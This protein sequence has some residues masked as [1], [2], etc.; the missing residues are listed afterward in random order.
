MNIHPE[1]LKTL[2][3]RAGLT[4]SELAEMLPGKVSLSTIKR[5]E[6]SKEINNA[7]PRIARA[8][9]HGLNCRDEELAKPPEPPSSD[10]KRNPI[11]ADVPIK[12]QISRD[13]VQSFRMNEFLYG[14]S[15][16]AQIEMAPLLFKLMAEGSLK[17]RKE[18][19]Q[20]ILDAQALLQNEARGHLSYAQRA[21]FELQGPGSQE[22][23]S[24]RNKDIFG[25][26]VSEESY[27]E[28]YDRWENNPFL[29]YIKQEV[30]RIGAEQ[31][32]FDEHGPSYTGLPDFT[33]DKNEFERLICPDEENHQ[34]ISEA[35]IQ[36]IVRLS[37]LPEELRSNSKHDE[38]I[39]WFL[40]RL[41]PQKKEKL[42][43]EI[44][45][46]ID[47]LLALGAPQPTTQ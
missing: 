18:K 4:Q 34:L 32:E 6:A 44:Q 10:K 2:R 24:I 33:T 41:P 11:G 28:G 38:R 3:N 21:V 25:K 42:Q 20:N 31:V 12:E 1:A 29:A 27:V 36:G 26:D 7:R 30:Q 37:D 15:M 9:A 45:K 47:D 16:R 40:E 5:M 14:V 19:L 8:L 22:E 43:R 13:A 35:I 46:G 17:W 39:K 23:D